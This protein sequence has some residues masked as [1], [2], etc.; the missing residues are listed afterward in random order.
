MKAIVP[1]LIFASAAGALIP[2]GAADLKT[3]EGWQAWGFPVDD[4][5][6][7]NLWLQHA[8]I[9]ASEG[10][11]LVVYGYLVA[12][13]NSIV[14]FPTEEASQSGSTK[15]ALVLARDDSPA[16]RWLFSEERSEGFYAVGGVFSRSEKGPMLGHLTKIRFAMKKEPNK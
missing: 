10:K 9:A 12:T 1:F 13:P 2:P 6:P 14:L 8:S 3:A 4:F 7:W 16:L 11:Y 15:G 5:L